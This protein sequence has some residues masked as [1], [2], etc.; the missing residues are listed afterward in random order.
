MKRIARHIGAYLVSI[1]IAMGVLVSAAA[2]TE[3]ELVFGVY[4][5]LSAR[6]MAEQFHPLKEHLSQVLGRRVALR[7]APDFKRFADRTREGEYDLIFN[8][9]HMAR[10]AQTRDGYRPLAQSGYRIVI[11]AIARTDSPVQSL[12]DLRG[13]S[14]AIGAR[15]SMTHQIIGK[16]LQHVGL[17]LEKDVKFV[18]AA[19]FSNV[20]Q[21]VV[22]GEADA[23]ATGSLL[24]DNAAAEEKRGLR[25]VF[26]QK[27]PLPGFI[28]AAHPRLGDATLKKLQAALLG[29]KDRPEGRDYFLKTHQVDFRTVDETTM[30]SIDPYT[31]ILLQQ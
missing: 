20:L 16:E 8:A 22:R 5:Y 24:W 2:A 14:L 13:R 23:G 10:V 17:V 12:A 27:D 19:S 4:P 6:Q 26:R 18:D 28:V 31:G 11:V 1:G 30:R 3:G 25:E 9:P 29:F 21:A 15:L 7:S